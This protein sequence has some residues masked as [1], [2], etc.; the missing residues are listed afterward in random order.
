VTKA[1]AD[2]KNNTKIKLQ[3]TAVKSHMLNKLAPLLVSLCDLLG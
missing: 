1:L 3:T 2:G